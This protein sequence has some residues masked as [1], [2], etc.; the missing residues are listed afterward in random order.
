M[1]MPTIQRQI[2]AS[3]RH[4]PQRELT[5]TR[6]SLYGRIGAAFTLVYFVLVNVFPAEAKSWQDVIFC[7]PNAITLGVAAVFATT[8]IATRDRPLEGHTLRLIDAFGL[9]LIGLLTAGYGWLTLRELLFSYNGVLA[10]T[11]AMAFRAALVPSPARRTMYLGLVAVAPTVAL[12]M[13]HS[14]MPGVSV[15]GGAMLGYVLA[16]CSVGVG[17]STVISGVIFGLRRRAQRAE[18]VG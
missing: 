5:Q 7:L 3:T 13:T 4:D 1:A 14:L 10:I 6:L 8:W 2:S 11:N 17:I 12:V 16:W 18:R 9:T 15:Q